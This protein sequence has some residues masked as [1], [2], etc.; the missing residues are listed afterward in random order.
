MIKKNNKYCIEK[1][2]RNIFKLILKHIWQSQQWE[3]NDKGV[4]VVDIYYIIIF[5]SKEI[6]EY[7]L[8]YITL[9]FIISHLKM[10]IILK[11]IQIPV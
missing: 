1:L 11:L 7:I 9:K 5:C 3:Y 2:K 4:F 6:F 10:I 8:S